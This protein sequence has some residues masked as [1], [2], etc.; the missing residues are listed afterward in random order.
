VH[1]CPCVCVCVCVCAYTRVCASLCV[2]VHARAFVS[3]FVL[4]L[5]EAIRVSRKGLGRSRVSLG[6]FG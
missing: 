2:C 3:V 1:V 5:L 6:E 4:A